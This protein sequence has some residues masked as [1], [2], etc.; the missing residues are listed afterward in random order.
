MKFINKMRK[1]T[2]GFTLVEIIVVLVILA[3]LAAFT[4][5]AMLGFVTDAKDK[6][7]IAEAREIYVASQSIATEVYATTNV[8]VTNLDGS[9]DASGVVAKTPATN[10]SLIQMLGS[11]ISE[12]ASWTVAVTDGKVTKVDYTIPG[13]GGRHIIIEGGKTTIS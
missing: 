8:G 5:P 10:S 2:K 9:A 11:D 1:K 7:H 4:I 13:T 12:G 3:I 6:A